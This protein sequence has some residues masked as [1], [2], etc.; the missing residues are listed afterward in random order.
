MLN[1]DAAGSPLISH[2]G[3]DIAGQGRPDPNRIN[4]YLSY[5]LVLPVMA[6]IGQ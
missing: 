4:R 3:R 5:I 2:L 1:K 6:E